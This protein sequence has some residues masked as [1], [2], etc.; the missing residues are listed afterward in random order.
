MSDAALHRAAEE[1]VRSRL[2][3][4]GVELE[5]MAELPDGY[6]VLLPAGR[7]Y[8]AMVLVRQGPHARGSGNTLGMHWTVRSDVEDFVA[9]VDLSRQAVWLLP[10]ADFRSRARPQ[11]GGRWHL[12]WL[13]SGGSR[14]RLPGESEFERYRLDNVLAAGSLAP[15]LEP[16]TPDL[17]LLSKES[18]P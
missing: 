10:S 14:S 7:M 18:Q 16:R 13:V 5:R 6:A 9:L 3:V 2:A 11:K 12:D 4:G 15:D 8:V 1:L 17:Q